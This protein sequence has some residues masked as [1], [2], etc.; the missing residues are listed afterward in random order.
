[1]RLLLL[2]IRGVHGMIAHSISTM[3]NSRQC[4]L[5]FTPSYN[6]HSSLIKKIKRRHEYVFEI[7]I[8]MN[9]INQAFSY[10]TFIIFLCLIR[11]LCCRRIQASLVARISGLQ[12]VVCLLINDFVYYV[13]IWIIVYM[14]AN[15]TFSLRWNCQSLFSVTEI[16]AGE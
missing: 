16:E 3:Y 7:G 15:V 6:C 8:G 4:L 13:F 10:I 12:L 5:R 9:D 2:V 14:L 1:M 11:F